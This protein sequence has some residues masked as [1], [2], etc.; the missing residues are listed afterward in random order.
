[1]LN[2]IGE[3]IENKLEAIAG[4]GDRIGTKLKNATV[5]AI[6]GIGKDAWD[7][8]TNI[9]QWVSDQAGVIAGWGE[10]IGGKIKSGLIGGLVGLAG[11][12]SQIAT[13]A[14][15]AVIRA[16]N[17]FHIPSFHI[18]IPIPFA[19]D[20]NFDTPE[21][22]FP[23]IPYLAKGGIALSPTLAMIGEAGPEAIVPLGRGGGELGGGGITINFPN[24][25]VIGGDMQ[26][27]ARELVSTMEREL[28]ER[29]RVGSPILKAAV[30]GA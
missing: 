1:V 30:F 6:V 26:Q 25:T 16:W 11:I 5:G 24:A 29:S 8:V 13:A 15:N 27:L 12:V 14:V 17:R 19:P 9:G 7:T 10:S 22:D 4:W 3:W 21:I 18:H 2:N 20:I 28:R 23:N